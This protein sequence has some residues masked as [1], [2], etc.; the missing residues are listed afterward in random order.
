[1]ALISPFRHLVVYP[2]MM[3]KLSTAWSTAH[4]H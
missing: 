1:M 2:T 3:R 4:A